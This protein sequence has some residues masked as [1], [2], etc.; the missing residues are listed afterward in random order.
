VSWDEA[1]L[2][3][4]APTARPSVGAGLTIAEV[5]EREPDELPP[6]MSTGLDEL[7]LALGGGIYGE[8]L[9][10]VAAPT[11][12]GKSSLAYQIARHVSLDH[13]VT[14]LTTEL[15]A[16][17]V[18]C[19]L[20]AQT[21]GRSWLELWR[22][23]D[24][25]AMTNA[26]SGHRIRIVD[27]TASRDLSIREA[28][29]GAELAVVDYIQDVARR[30]DDRREM[31]HVVAAAS[32]EIR[33]WALETGGAALVVSSAARTWGDSRAA[34]ERVTR[35]YASA[36]KEAGELESDAS[37]VIA[38]DIE[39]CPLGGV[40]PAILRIGKGRYSTAGEIRLEY[41][42]A[43]GLFRTP[44]GP[45]L[46][47]F[48]AEV[49]DATG[50][51]VRTGAAIARELGCRKDKALRVLRDLVKRRVLTPDFSLAEVTI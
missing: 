8:S 34:A 42:G 25:E 50:R 43:L 18:V 23:F 14:I 2:A 38:V 39:P 33:M 4:I 7:N 21:L 13:E 35:D 32:D 41:V 12:R 3:A 10:L 36:G 11:G 49:L 5:L 44:T 19:R 45:V 28:I 40:A 46:S 29:G 22:Q 30:R 1:P 17:Q 27:A 31:R 24:R 15:R 47:E 20:A 26:L 48:E 6:P 9:Y 37:A 51:G 16:R